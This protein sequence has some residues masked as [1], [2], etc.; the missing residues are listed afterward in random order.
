MKPQPHRIPRNGRNIG[1]SPAETRLISTSGMQAASRRSPPSFLHQ[2]Y[3]SPGDD[4]QPYFARRQWTR[5][6][7]RKSVTAASP[8]LENDSSP[9]SAIR[10][11]AL[12]GIIVILAVLWAGR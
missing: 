5:L 1:G 2:P 9:F 7:A 12:L 4:G 8:S 11:I 10:V 6:P 3:R